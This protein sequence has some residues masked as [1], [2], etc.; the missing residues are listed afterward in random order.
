MPTG[1]HTIFPDRMSLF[2]LLVC[3]RCWQNGAHCT[4]IIARTFAQH[5]RVNYVSME[6]FWQL[7]RTLRVQQVRWVWSCVGSLFTPEP[8]HGF[9]L[10]GGYYCFF[11]LRILFVFQP[12]AA[13]LAICYIL[14]LK[15][16][17]CMHFG[18]RISHLRAHLAFGFWLL[19]FGLWLWL[20][21]LHLASLGCTWLHLASLGFTWL[22][23]AYSSWLLAFGFGFTWLW[24]WPFTSLGSWRLLGFSIVAHNISCNTLHIYIY[25]M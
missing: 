4:L 21:L 10:K 19:A 7:L 12:G 13:F 15:S 14:E 8:E 25:F 18:A 11:L 24:F 3:F 16:V 20:L 17:F 5:I 23:L 1:P 22:H 9:V 6:K 2:A